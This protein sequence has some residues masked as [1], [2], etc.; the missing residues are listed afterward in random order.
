MTMAT[1]KAFD[2]CTRQLKQ[3][4]KEHT[5]RVERPA[6]TKV[7][8]DH[9]TAV[10]ERNAFEKA[11]EEAKAEI[12]RRGEKIQELTDENKA[13]IIEKKF[14]ASDIEK[15]KTERIVQE[16]EKILGLKTE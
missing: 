15:L 16:T 13:H 8:M 11:L 4:P 1:S 7:L 9:A 14:L 6:I 10:R 12:V 3:R 5:P 2:L